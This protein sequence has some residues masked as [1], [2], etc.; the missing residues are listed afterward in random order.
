MTDRQRGFTLL[1]V[2]VATGVV[3]AMAATMIE[4][5]RNARTASSV[6]SD[7]ADAQQKLRVAAEA[8]RHDLLL[9]GAGT[10][11]GPLGQFLPPIRPSAGLTGE[12]DLTFATDRVTL[13]WV[14][15]EAAE[16]NVTGPAGSGGNLA[17]G[18]SAD[19]SVDP[20]CGFEA[21]MQAV[22]VDRTGPGFGYDVFTVGD[23]FSG[24]LT[25][26]SDGGAFSRAYTSSA[27]V[28]QVVRH[29]YYLDRS[30]PANVRLMRGNGRD[31]FP[32]VDDV[33]DLRFTY[34]AD[35]DPASVSTGGAATG[36]CVYA[37]GAP[38]RPL[39]AVLGGSSLAEL[40]ASDLVDGPFCGFA[41]NRFDADLLRIRR[42]RVFLRIEP[43]SAGPRSG[44]PPLSLELS[45][46]VTPP[47]LN[48]SR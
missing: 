16:A 10:T 46:D 29:V 34:F 7:M 20:T 24:E 48:L 44:G 39:L 27:Q 28:G 15:P 13:L 6:L 38:P 30:D 41:P 1:E 35:P 23:A 22:I 47:N 3:L 9:A 4:V 17:I 25:R 11:I 32:L 33:G 8:I 18:N 37:A 19:C 36:T 5:A 45:F 2:L 31:A 12:T 21:G 43:R 42:V 14:P 26:A 40:A